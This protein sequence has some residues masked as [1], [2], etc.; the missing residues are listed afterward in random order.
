ME[1][2]GGERGDWIRQGIT[3]IFVRGTIDPQQYIVDNVEALLLPYLHVLQNAAFQQDNA[4]PHNTRVT[5]DPV[6][7][8]EVNLNPCHPKSSDIPLIQN[9]WDVIGIRLPN[10]PR[11]SESLEGFQ[12]QM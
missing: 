2:T 9:G 4:Q 1:R 8:V 12:H 3:L 10:L 7:E 11:P 6:E 5:L